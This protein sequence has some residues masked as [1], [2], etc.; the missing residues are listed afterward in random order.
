MRN[1]SSILLN[2]YNQNKQLLNELGEVIYSLLRTLIKSAVHTHQITYRVKDKDSLL[3]KIIRK[4]YKYQHLN[5]ITDL[6]G[7]R[8]ILYFE[9][10]IDEVEKIIRKEFKIDEKNSIDKRNIDTD[11]FGYR[12]LHYVATLNN[13]RLMLPEY[14]K[15][16]H[17]KFE[18]QIRSILQ[19]SWA[20]IEHD[21]GYKGE[22]EI[23]QEA[24]RTFYRIAA[25]LEQAD[26]EFVKLKNELKIH[27][28]GLIKKISNSTTN[29]LIDKASL[30][31]YIIESPVINKLEKEIESFLCTREENFYPAIIDNL[32]PRLQ[33]K[34]ITYISQLEEL[35][36][37]HETELINWLKMSSKTD[38]LNINSFFKGASIL[39]L[40]N[41]IETHT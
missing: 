19:H 9:D 32:L 36:K 25:L 34:K 18:I 8:I 10:D 22:S 23:P 29:I 27:E 37:K 38:S 16:E 17:I 6:V 31:A 28:L 3:K 40:L 4:N 39:W 5:E 7:F 21:I 41:L 33:E 26:I 13:K 11:K 20:E 12:S 14:E 30:K 35:L 1:K 15:F 2:E 24:K